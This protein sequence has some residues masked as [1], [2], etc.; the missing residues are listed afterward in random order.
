MPAGA[1]PSATGSNSDRQVE[2]QCFDHCAA[3]S[4]NPFNFFAAEC[5]AEVL[6]PIIAAWIKDANYFQRE[7][8]VHADALGFASIAHAAGKP[9]VSSYRWAALGL[10]HDMFKFQDLAED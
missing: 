5:P 3:N 4:R 9:E 6:G 10:G 8:V 1:D 2:L 7:R